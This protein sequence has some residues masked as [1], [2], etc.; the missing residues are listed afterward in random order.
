MVCNISEA[1]TKR[2]ANT[3]YSPGRGEEEKEIADIHEGKMAQSISKI[4]G[5]YLLVF[6]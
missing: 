1:T 3:K 6:I 4:K 2:L 5:Q